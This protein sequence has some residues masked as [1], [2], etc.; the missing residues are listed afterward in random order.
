MHAPCN[1][2]NEGDHDTN[3]IPM[4]ANAFLLHIPAPE[5]NVRT[6]PY[7]GGGGGG[8]GATKTAEC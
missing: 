4:K 3:K 8:G 5:A 6:V 2:I 1:S 7:G